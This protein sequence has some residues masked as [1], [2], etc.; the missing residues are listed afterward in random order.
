MT[1]NVN[2][3]G[4]SGDEAIARAVARGVSAGIAAYDRQLPGRVRQINRDPR[5]G[6]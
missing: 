3:T 5:G 2:V 6:R 1:I 4:T